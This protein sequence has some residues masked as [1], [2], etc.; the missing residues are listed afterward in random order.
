MEQIIN[1]YQFNQLQSAMLTTDVSGLQKG[2]YLIGF[3][4]KQTTKFIVK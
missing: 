1:N 2:T 3:G 4:Q